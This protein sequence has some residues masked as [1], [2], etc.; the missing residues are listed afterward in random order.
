[1][2]IIKTDI[3]SILSAAD[4]EFFNNKKILIT[5][6]SG[7]L[8]GYFAQTLQ[9]GLDLGSQKTR[10]FLSSKSGKFQFDIEPQV[11]IIA[12]DLSDYKIIDK[13]PKFDLIIH[14]AGYSAP[15][16]FLDDPLLTIKLNTATTSK[17]L[18]KLNKNSK[19]LFVSSSEVYSGLECPPFRESQIGLT[20]TDH[21]RSSYIEGKRSGEAI[22]AAINGKNGIDAKSVRLSLVYGPGT[23]KG[24]KRVLNSFIEQG[25]C[26]SRIEL[27][28]SGSALRTYCYVVDAVEMCF[29]AII[30]GTELIYNVGG[31]SQISI[32]DLAKLI[33]KFTNSDLSIPR[34]KG[35]YLSS[36]P[37]SVSLD[38]SKILAL[39]NNSNFIGLDEGLKRTIDWQKKVLFSQ[40]SS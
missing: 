22:M 29:L 32:V 38:L 28:D 3:L 34:I 6:A 26:S 24:D 10:L 27:K 39:K 40:F 16:S 31:I 19:F 9:Q 37:T 1:M 7:L 36:A 11:E 14:S 35:S 15:G 8:G 21:V 4:I 17:L 33:A 18:E 23:K 13:L 2:D 12:G 5:G 20:N 25:I 30:H